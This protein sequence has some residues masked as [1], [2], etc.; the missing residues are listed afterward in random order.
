MIKVFMFIDVNKFEI[1]YKWYL[2]VSFVAS[3]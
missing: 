3:M 1:E 2:K